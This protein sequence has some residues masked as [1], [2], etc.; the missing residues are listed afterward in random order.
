M[1]SSLPIVKRSRRS[2]AEAGPPVGG[3]ALLKHRSR[4]TEVALLWRD[5][6][7][8]VQGGRCHPLMADAS[9]WMNPAVRSDLA[10]LLSSC[11]RAT[12]ALP[13]SASARPGRSSV[14][15]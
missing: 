9:G 8:V 6:P 1:R 14:A 13:S 5:H 3:E 15:R 4:R 11:M 2:T 10:R 7:E 12:K